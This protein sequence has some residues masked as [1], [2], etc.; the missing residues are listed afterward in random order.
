M[1]GLE[2]VA[3]TIKIEF[4]LGRKRVDDD[5]FGACH[6]LGGHLRF[7]GR[8]PGLGICPS[9]DFRE[10]RILAVILEIV[11]RRNRVPRKGLGQ[12]HRDHTGILG[13][14]NTERP[15]HAIGNVKG[16]VRVNVAE[17][18]PGQDVASEGI[19]MPQIN[20]FSHLRAVNLACVQLRVCA[21]R[22]IE[23]SAGGTENAGR[24]QQ[25]NRCHCGLCHPR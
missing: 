15:L 25:G 8:D 14:R 3:Q 4:G 13:Q 2:H 21:E 24:N 12:V 6:L 23:I 16:P 9:V 22:I 7:E 1:T 5:L 20:G 17:D 10:L 19:F 18:L 11:G